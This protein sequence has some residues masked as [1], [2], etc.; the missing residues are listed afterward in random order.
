MSSPSDRP[1]ILTLFPSAVGGGAERLVLDQI[2][3][4]DSVAYDYSAIALRKGKLHRRFS[5][6]P[7][8]SSVCAG[9]RFNPLALWKVHR[10]IRSRGVDILHT[11][12]QEA[13][14]YGFLL[15]GLNPGLIW[16]STR[17]NADDFRTRPFWRT[18]NAVISRRVDRVIAV[19]PCVSGFVALY[20]RI[21]E[22]KLVV[23]RN[24]IDLGRFA[25]RPSQETAKKSLGLAAD[26]FV[27]GMVG[28][29]VPQK[30]HKY[31]LQAAARLQADIPRLR[32]LVVGEGGLRRRLER[33]SRTLGIA[34]RVCF[35]GFRDDVAALYPAMD[36]FCI[37]SLFE[38]F[39]LVLMEALI[40]ERVAVGAR[41]Y[42]ISDI[43][44]D[45]RNG[46]LVDPADV[47]DLAAAILRVHRG[48]YDR[49]MAGRA[50]EEGLVAYDFKSCLRQVEAVYRELMGARAAPAAHRARVHDAAGAV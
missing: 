23:V 22:D 13:D 47:G 21:A 44:E 40:C 48:E 27:I 35:A 34:D 41:T 15:K 17:H 28:R 29:L 18:L 32:L 43:I 14:F 11:H 2:R 50:R 46:L 24:G 36:L 19:S 3:F 38:G 39:P 25:H 4:H 9:V 1:R 42:G 26:D 31:L 16:M 7:Q 20:E 5:A 49:R 30:G 12:L 8:Y 33:L 45:G 6:F 10:F 37:P